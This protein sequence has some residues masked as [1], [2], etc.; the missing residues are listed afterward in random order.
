LGTGFG[1]TGIGMG[2]GT[3]SAFGAQQGSSV[4]G[5]AGAGA[6]G[7]QG[8][9]AIQQ[10]G[11]A[12]TTGTTAT[13]RGTMTRG[14][15]TQQQFGA[16]TTRGGTTAR[17][18]ARGQTRGATTASQQTALQIRV[19]VE[20]GFEAP[21]PAPAVVTSNLVSLLDRVFTDRNLGVAPQIEMDG[22]TIVLRGLVAS[23][24]QRQVVARLVAMQPG[25][26][27]VRNL[28]VVGTA[29]GDSTEQQDN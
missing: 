24:S 25:V 12:G 29:S 16:T 8:Y 1:Q 21:T 4:I 15:T 6:P 23:E 3:T 5:R 19:N 11:Y 22:G 13:G 7:Q 28:L 9:N 20:L 17:G 27:S 26:S 2:T 10:G 14:V 18:Q